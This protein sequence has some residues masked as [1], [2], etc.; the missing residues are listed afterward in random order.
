MRDAGADRL[1]YEVA[2]M[3]AGNQPRVHGDAGTVQRH[4]VVAL[5]E[6]ASP[7]LADPKP[8]S[9]PGNGP[10]DL[11]H[12]VAQ[13]HQIVVRRLRSTFGAEQHCCATTER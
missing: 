12:A 3:V 11:K 1:R 10:A 2:D 9:F 5:G 7:V 8:P 6:S 4:P 13:E